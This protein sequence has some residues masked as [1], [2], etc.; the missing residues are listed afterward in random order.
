MVASSLL[1]ASAASGQTAIPYSVERVFPNAILPQNSL[2]LEEAPDGSQRLFVVGQRGVIAA[3][4]NSPNPTGA[5]VV[6][7]LDINGRV[8]FRGEQGLLGLAFPPNYATSREFY[9]YYTFGTND[10]STSPG[11]SRL[12][13][14]RE[15]VTTPGLGD[16]NSEEILLTFNQPF[17]NHNGGGLQ[18][19]PDG[20]L[21]LATGDGGSSNDPQNN[22]QNLGNLLGKIL[23]LDVL[24]PTSQGL[25]YGIPAN[26]PFLSTQ[27]ARGEIWAYG[28][29]NPYRFSFDRERGFLIAGDVG[30]NAREEVNHVVAG[31]NYGWR[32]RE[33][34]LCTPTVQNNPC[35]IDGVTFIEPIS[36]YAH[37]GG[38]RSITGGF[39]YY[40][41][42]NP[43]LRGHYLFADYIRGD[44]FA[45]EYDGTPGVRT[46]RLLVNVGFNVSGFGQTSDGE[47]YF[48]RYLNNGGEV[49]RLRSTQP[50]SFIA[51]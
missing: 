4:P 39:V 6:T 16:P 13:R 25:A 5:E 24:G 35:E 12:S 32:L 1:F 14:F 42:R 33:G 43:E 47:V 27:G 15:S 45:I 29:R 49:Y 40:G 34:T 26:N 46:P 48:T 30:Q 50:T 18:F 22:A 3:F 8:L 10:N 2:Q 37:V 51:R 38:G 11:P 31:G 36:E 19:G 23:R 21:Y 20:M 9:L 7:Y 17:T 44:L 41:T 28:L